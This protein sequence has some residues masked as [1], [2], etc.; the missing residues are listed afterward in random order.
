[1]PAPSSNGMTWKQKG[2]TTMPICFLLKDENNAFA[3]T[4][5]MNRLRQM[6]A[7]QPVCNNHEEA[8][9]VVLFMF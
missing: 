2:G 4:F 6:Q 5:D 8:L 1:M 3:N 9:P 7:I